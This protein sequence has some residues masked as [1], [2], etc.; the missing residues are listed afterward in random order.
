M[1]GNLTSKFDPVRNALHIELQ[2]FF[3]LFN[4]CQKTKMLS[5]PVDT[6]SSTTHAIP[7]DFMHIPSTFGLLCCCKN[8]YIQGLLMD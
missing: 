2:T 6:S 4:Y 8:R 7:N 5:Y 3:Y 1:V